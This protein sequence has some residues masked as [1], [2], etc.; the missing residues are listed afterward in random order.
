M[1][2]L[3]TTNTIPIDNDLYQLLH[4]KKWR[5]IQGRYGK[6]RFLMI[7]PSKQKTKRKKKLLPKRVS[8]F[9]V[10]LVPPKQAAKSGDIPLC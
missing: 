8:V 5:K 9:V 10:K 1:H 4:L 7:K 6:D 2:T 3:T